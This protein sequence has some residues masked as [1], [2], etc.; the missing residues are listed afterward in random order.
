MNKIATCEIKRTISNISHNSKQVPWQKHLFP[1][2]GY[3]IPRIPIKPQCHDRIPYPRH[4]I[5]TTSHDKA[6]FDVISHTRQHQSVA[7]HLVVHNTTLTSVCQDKQPRVWL[8][9]QWAEPRAYQEAILWHWLFCYC[10]RAILRG[11]SVLELDSI[12][13]SAPSLRAYTCTNA[14][15][16]LF[17]WH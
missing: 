12:R 14:G 3:T 8:R 10:N 4:G 1:M 13:H 6:S 11:Q 7:N 9:Q 5:C 16:A 17:S 15:T 2:K